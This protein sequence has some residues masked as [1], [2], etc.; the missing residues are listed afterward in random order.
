[1]GTSK[2]NKFDRDEIRWLVDNLKGRQRN[3]IMYEKLKDVITDGEVVFDDDDDD[4]GWKGYSTENW[5]V[6]SG[7]VGEWLQN[8]ATPQDRRNFKDFMSM[9]EVF[10]KSRGIDARR[11]MEK[12]GN[13]IT[14]R[15]GPMLNVALKFYVE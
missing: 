6:R 8:V 12:Q 11:S 9:L 5:A 3:K 15:L 13:A 4:D 10:E 14:V 7:S 1:M 2:K